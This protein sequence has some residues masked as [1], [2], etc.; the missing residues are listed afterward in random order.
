MRPRRQYFK[1]Y[2]YTARAVKAVDSLIPVGGPATAAVQWVRDGS[3]VG[4]VRAN[5]V[6]IDFIS[7]HLYPT[8]G[9]VPQARD[10]F[11]STI[12]ATAQAAAGF[13][14]PLLVTEFSAGI[15]IDKC[16]DWLPARRPASARADSCEPE[17][18]PELSALALRR[19]RGSA[20]APTATTLPPNGRRYDEPYAAAFLAHTAAAFQDVPNVGLLSYWT[21]TGA[22]CVR[23]RGSRGCERERARSALPPRELSPTLGR[24]DIFEEDGFDS[25]PYAQK[26]VGEPQDGS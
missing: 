19:A 6:P 24:A 15:W 26:F 20:H 8:D 14:L 5:G 11:E 7:T 2:D 9:V 13:G 17:W 16:V 23:R 25:T 22:D 1:L 3:F 10:G 4:F 21:F 18:L 12:N